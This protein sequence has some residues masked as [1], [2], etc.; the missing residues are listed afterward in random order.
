[1]KKI[2]LITICLFSIC[3]YNYALYIHRQAILNLEKP[4]SNYHVLEINCRSGYRGASNILIEF[5]KK[6]YYVG[7]S[8][9]Q[10]KSFKPQNINLYYD[11]ENDIIFEKNDLTIKDLV[12]YFIL[13]LSSSL[14][15]I[16]DIIKEKRRQLQ[17]YVD[18]PHQPNQKSYSDGT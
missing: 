14:W 4:I 12:F 11:K 9:N 2:I 13:F 8:K 17:K 1:M 18:A 6:Q 7:I 3:V 10:C 16:Y 15:L 5:N